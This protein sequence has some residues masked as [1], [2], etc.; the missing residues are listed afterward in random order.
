MNDVGS[1]SELSSSGHSQDPIK[2]DGYLIERSDIFFTVDDLELLD[3]TYF[4]IL[5]VWLSVTTQ[6]I[7]VA[8]K[9]SPDP[10]EVLRQSNG[11]FFLVN[12]LST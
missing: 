2:S 4:K 5:K 7:L 8:P 12:R 3:A 6:N 10:M 1:D 11:N 9:K